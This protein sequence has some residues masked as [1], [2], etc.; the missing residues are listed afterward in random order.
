MR[1]DNEMI[2]P[3]IILMVVE[4]KALIFLIW[5]WCDARIANIM[6]TRNTTEVER[7]MFAELSKGR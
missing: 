1:R 3:A 4:I 5:S 2:I 6:N 7:K